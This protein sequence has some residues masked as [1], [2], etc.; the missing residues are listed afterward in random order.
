MLTFKS[1]M[2]IWTLLAWL[3]L[4]SSI[5]YFRSSP[6]SESVLQ[7]MAVSAHGAVIAL[8]CSVA[9]LVAIFGS[10]RQEYGEIYRLLLWVPLFLV[11][12]S[13]F[14]FRG[15]KEIHFLQLLNILWL[16]FAFLFGGMAITGVWL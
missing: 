7:R 4:V 12:Y 14:R 5:V 10:P 2:T 11:A 3:P 16:I 1:A 13:F 8:L 15:K 6:S 9:L